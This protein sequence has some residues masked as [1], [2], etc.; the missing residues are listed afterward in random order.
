M[1]NVDWQA[2]AAIVCVAVAGV[3]LA[4]RAVRLFTRPERAGCGDGACA[5]CPSSGTSSGTERAA[6]PR[7]LVTLETSDAA[8]ARSVVDARPR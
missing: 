5:K 6:E 2:V 4:R 8:R 1:G 3:W 7:P